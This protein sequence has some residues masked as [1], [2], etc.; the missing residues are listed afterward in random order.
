MKTTQQQRLFI[1]PW[2]QL[3]AQSG[4]WSNSNEKSDEYMAPF[5]G[6]TLYFLDN[7]KAAIQSI[8]SQL[9]LSAEDEVFVTNSTDSTYVS[10][11][12]TCTIFNHCKPS[13][14][15][16]D[17]TRVIFIIHEHG[18]AHSLT[19]SLKHEAAN[20]NI[21]LIEDC[22]HSYGTT[23]NKMPTGTFGDYS[24]F[25]LSKVFPIP[26]G[27]ILSVR[28]SSASNLTKHK[29]K[30]KPQI[31][32]MFDHYGPQLPFFKRRRKENY[33]FLEKQLGDQVLVRPLEANAVPYFFAFHHPNAQ[34]IK[35]KLS[36]IEW[37]ATMDEQLLLHPIN[38]IITMHDLRLSVELLRHE[39]Q[40]STY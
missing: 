17:K 29:I 6:R 7:G 18:I 16:T 5:K 15:L 34:Q 26:E 37:G 31:Q 38:P 30:E 11:C 4:I 20:R 8:L 36:N 25:S 10:S 9:N 28:Q 35:R 27:G 33:R 21:P 14:V 32:T 23:F 12:V 3:K 19:A 13:R 24:I 40:R 39:F 2:Q 22:A 1:L